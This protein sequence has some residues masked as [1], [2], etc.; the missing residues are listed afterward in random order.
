MRR[1]T[2]EGP[3]ETGASSVGDL[4]HFPG[5][6]PW[7][8]ACRHCSFSA[9]SRGS[10]TPLAWDRDW[11]GYV[12]LIT[13]IQ[14]PARLSPALTSAHPPPAQR[15]GLCVCV[16]VCVCPEQTV[17]FFKYIRKKFLMEAAP[18]RIE[19]SLGAEVAMA[20]QVPLPTDMS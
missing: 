16:C 4:E 9:Q 2:P 8:A 6:T 18:G 1:L 12:V 19:V 13:W 20:T 5:S 14:L 3:L 15:N 17:H 10:P 7:P 11:P